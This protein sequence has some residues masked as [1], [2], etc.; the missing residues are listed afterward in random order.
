MQL[1]KTLEDVFETDFFCLKPIDFV[2]IILVLN[3]KNFETSIEKCFEFMCRLV[4]ILV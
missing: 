4:S 3:N 2:L 1:I